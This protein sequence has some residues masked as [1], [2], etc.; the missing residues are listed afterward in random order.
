MALLPVTPPAGIVKNGT[1]YANK[2]RWVDG[3]L[4]RF[5]NGFLKPIG[6]WSKLRA[7]AL[8][9][10][11]IGMYAYKD[12]LGASV[13]AVG[14]REKVYVLYD[15]AWT[16]ITPVGF[17]NDA[18][19]DPLGYG[20]YHYDV[21]DYGDVRSQSGLP[22]DSG[23]FSFDNWG[24]DLIFCFSGDGK[25]Y[26]WRP[27]SGGTADTIATVVTNAPTGCQAIMVTNERHLVAIG[28]GGDPRKVAWSDR[29]DRNNW[30]S[31]A[32]NTAGDVQIP[33][34]G[35]AL[36]AVK[37]QNDTIVFSDT[38]IDR[39][40][41]VGS[42][43]IYGITAAGANCKA[44]SRRSIVQTGNFLAWMGENSFFVY[45]GVVREIPCDVHDYVYDQ[46]NV[47][48]RKACW[49]G[50]NSNFNEIWWGF[51]SGEGQYKA[52]K[53]VIWNYRENVWSIGELD[54]GCWI[55]QGAFDYPI[56]GDSLGFVY[57]HESTTLSNSPNLGS[58]VPFATSGPIELGN[59][60]NY[61]QCNQII[62]DEEAN[63]LPGVTIG[64]K[65][66]FTPLGPT[67]DFGNFTFESDGYTDARFTARQV[68]MTVTGS[69]TQDFQV[70]NIRLNLR[71]RGRR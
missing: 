27:V 23:H 59:G 62:P 53:Y 46:L 14:T 16:D 68:Q 63:A 1:D 7:T 34:G 8:D 49:G 17:V 67:T 43:F 24:E 31:K 64:F 41:Y 66:K 6:G 5:E 29:E 25:I 39:M 44:V 71:N 22:L 3:N 48:G 33:T 58:A 28:S 42:P 10:E 70:G 40:S 47:P 52:N 20:A 12:N 15:N 61:V 2:G 57:E 11:P 26:K 50:H 36:L 38:G 45:D 54:R 19:N 51:P 60:D 65:G 69:T 4:V 35:R 32:T 56:S 13:L 30:T 9:G 21:E 18:S 55:D 37:Y